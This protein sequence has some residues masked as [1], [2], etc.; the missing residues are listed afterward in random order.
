MIDA[1]RTDLPSIIDTFAATAADYSVQWYADIA[2]DEPF[3]AELPP[4]EIIATER[5]VQSIEWAVRNGAKGAAFDDV[6]T[7]AV[8]EKNL[9]GATDLMVYDSSRKVVV[10]L[11]AVKEKVTYAR[12]AREVRAPRAA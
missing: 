1:L 5:I 9:T 4:G 6:V 12:V 2:P 11:N 3:R 7:K 8:G 10:E